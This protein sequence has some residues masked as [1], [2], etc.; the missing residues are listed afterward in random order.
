MTVELLPGGDFRRTFAYDNGNPVWFPYSVERCT[1][2][3]TPPSPDACI[4][5]HY[6]ATTLEAGADDPFG[7][8]NLGGGTVQVM[9]SLDENSKVVATRILSSPNPEL[10][11]L[12][13]KQTRRTKFRT[14]IVDCKPKAADYVFSVSFQ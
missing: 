11:M 3:K 6:P 7:S 4:A 2:G 12:A 1:P 13:L 10:N 9:V 8:Y 5:K 14:E